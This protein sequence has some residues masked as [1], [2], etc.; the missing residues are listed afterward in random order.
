MKFSDCTDYE[1]IV[2]SLASP[3]SSSIE[4]KEIYLS[5]L[6]FLNYK[7]LQYFMFA[8]FIIQQDAYPILTESNPDARFFFNFKS[9]DRITF[10]RLVGDK[11]FKE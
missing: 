7:D 11:D 3:F 9:N 8:K 6:L 1:R 10:R 5:Y 2:V 4:D